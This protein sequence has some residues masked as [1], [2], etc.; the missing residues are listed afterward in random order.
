MI[1]M[2]K[3]YCNNCNYNIIASILTDAIDVLSSYMF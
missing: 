3:D 1:E 2:R